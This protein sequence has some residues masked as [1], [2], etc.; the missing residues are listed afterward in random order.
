MLLTALP[1]SSGKELVAMKGPTLLRLAQKCGRVPNDVLTYAAL[2][3]QRIETLVKLHKRINDIVHTQTKL[4]C[5][6][7]NMWKKDLEFE[8]S[9][10]ICDHPTLC[11]LYLYCV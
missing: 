3:A 9:D 11:N 7:H 2:L 6:D 1:K 8:I 4:N 10:K 5:V